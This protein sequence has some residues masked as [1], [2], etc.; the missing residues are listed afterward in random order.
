MIT[1]KVVAPPSLIAAFAAQVKM[2]PIAWHIEPT[3]VSIVFEQGPKMRFERQPQTV[4]AIKHVPPSAVVPT[5]VQHPVNA[6]IASKGKTYTA[7][8][9]KA[10]SILPK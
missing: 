3:Y 7:H 8:K 6:R 10:K 2:T 5:V 9:S 1:P 4:G